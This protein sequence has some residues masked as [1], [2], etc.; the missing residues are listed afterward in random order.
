MMT[1]GQQAARL[2]REIQTIG[3]NEARQRINDAYVRN[4]QDFPSA[5]LLKSFTLQTEPPYNTGTIAITQNTSAITLSGGAWVTSWATAPSMRRMEIQGRREPYDVT[6]FGS[7]TTATLADNYP[8]TTLT[9]G[10]YNLYRDTY[11]LPADCGYA[12][13]MALYDPSQKSD[14]RFPTDRGR[15]LFFNQS[16][17]LKER[18]AQ[19]TLTGIPY[20]FTMMQQTTENPPRSQFQLFPAPSD[21][22]VYHG[23][24]FR[25]PAVMASDSEYPDW[26]EEF[27]D[28]HWV[29][30]CIDYYSTPR[31]FSNRF[32]DLFMKMKMEAFRKMKVE[33][34]GQSAMENDIQGTRV[35]MTSYSPTFYGSTVA[36][37][38]SWK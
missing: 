13:I 24:Y 15:L 35:G 33:M 9:A 5:H 36:G 18:A 10:A 1:L 3:A 2:I 7:T 14:I 6:T 27:E 4:A 31:H 8:S 22:R 20:C 23:W 38:V 16:R 21:V 11:A 12:K 19:N 26:P 28:M 32:R 37:S 25:R 34:D 17:F 30:A 29:Q